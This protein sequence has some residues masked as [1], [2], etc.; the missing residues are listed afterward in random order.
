MI[1]P[2]L[3][4]F[5]ILLVMALVISFVV[6]AEN[7]IEWADFISVRGATDG[8]QHG[9][10]DSIGKGGGVFICIYIPLLYAH[11]EKFEPLGG[12]ALLGVSLAY[13][14]AVNGYSAYLRSKQG[15]VQTTTTTAPVDDT[16]LKTTVTQ[17]ETPPIQPTTPE[18]PKRSRK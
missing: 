3:I 7:N 15:T 4:Q 6:N 17:T 2:L 10:W 18:T 8:K 1:H 12:A 5:G 16:P 13:L 11:S 9:S 14:G